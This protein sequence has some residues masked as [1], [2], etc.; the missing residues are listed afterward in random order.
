MNNMY[1]FAN[2]DSF[3]LYRTAEN[4]SSVIADFYLLESIK[5]SGED[6]SD[7]REYI[8]NNLIKLAN[9]FKQRLLEEVKS[10][11]CIEYVV[12]NY[13]M[14]SNPSSIVYDVLDPKNHYNDSYYKSIQMFYMQLQKFSYEGDDRIRKLAKQ[15]INIPTIDEFYNTYIETISSKFLDFGSYIGKPWNNIVD[16][17]KQLYEAK[18]L[19]NIIIAL[20]HIIDLQ[21]VT[22]SIFTRTSLEID[23]NILDIKSGQDSLWELYDYASPGIKK[24]TAP[25]IKK[26]EGKGYDMY[27]EQPKKEYLP[28]S[29][30]VAER[31]P[32]NLTY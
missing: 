23:D 28:K 5:N 11:I 29:K 16:A 1:K 10:A 3:L 7:V 26:I 4:I 18:D 27:Q 8:T 21:H 17:W 14:S 25:I 15:E 19:N 2:L 30:S 32:E 20:D 6:I 24:V 31:Y 12:I 9:D 22:G 13:V